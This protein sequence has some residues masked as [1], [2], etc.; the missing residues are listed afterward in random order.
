MRMR[1]SAETIVR[2]GVLQKLE[3]FLNTRGEE[4]SA[5]DNVGAPPLLHCCAPAPSSS[6]VGLTRTGSTQSRIQ[7]ICGSLSLISAICVVQRNAGLQTSPLV[8]HMAAMTIDKGT[9]EK[10]RCAPYAVQAGRHVRTPCTGR[11]L[12]SA[13]HRSGLAAA[14]EADQ[15]GIGV[16]TN[17]PGVSSR[18]D[19][20]L[21]ALDASV[22][23]AHQRH[24]R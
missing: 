9:G 14:I 6:S 19:D 7:A 21:P 10:V 18:T 15:G 5:Q 1:C 20:V 4:I 16:A 23:C 22:S 8:T 17:A 13:V 2:E 12:R 3:H 11:L 24:P